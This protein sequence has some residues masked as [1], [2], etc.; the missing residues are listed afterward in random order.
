MSAS[1]WPLSAPF[2]SIGPRLISA[3]DAKR[4]RVSLKTTKLAFC[5][6]RG[7]GARRRPSPKLPWLHR[8]TQGARH[9]QALSAL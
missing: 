2:T 7:S 4:A 3:V 5:P 6:S 9:L 8:D 1:R